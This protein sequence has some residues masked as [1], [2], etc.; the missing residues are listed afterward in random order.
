ME[1]FCNLS[2]NFLHWFLLHEQVLKSQ[3]DG[4]LSVK[5]RALSPD[6]AKAIWNQ[7]GFAGHSCLFPGVF[8]HKH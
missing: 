5:G 6:L 7:L 1:S 2:V 4:F 8:T 3:V